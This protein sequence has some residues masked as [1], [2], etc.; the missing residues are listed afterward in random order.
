MEAEKEKGRGPRVW[1]GLVDSHL[2]RE[3]CWPL[4]DVP[5]FDVSGVLQTAVTT[6]NLQSRR[7]QPVKFR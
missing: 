1:R 6:C 3:L 2:Q 7:S 5:S 4:A